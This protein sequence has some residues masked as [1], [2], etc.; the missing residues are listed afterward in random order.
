MLIEY[1]K[2]NETK[3]RAQLRYWSSAAGDLHMFGMKDIEKEELPK[4]LQSVYDE[5]WEECPLGLFCYLAQFLGTNGLLFQTEYHEFTE[6]GEPGEINNAEYAASVAGRLAE[7]FPNYIVIFGKELGIPGLDDGGDPATELSLFIPAKALTI[8]RR[9]EAEKFFADI[10]YRSEDG[11]YD[12]WNVECR[13]Q[14]EFLL[15]RSLPSK[16]GEKIFSLLGNRYAEE[17]V[18]LESSERNRP[19]KQAEAL[20]TVFENLL[21]ISA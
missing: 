5:L 12:G 10:A 20:A 18:K 9:D 7:R 11:Y 19:E 16:R 8:E 15:A 3:Y 14:L 2:N 6:E 4:E 1:D 17:I 13:D 21:G